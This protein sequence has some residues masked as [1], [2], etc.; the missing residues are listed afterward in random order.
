M[1]S[2]TIGEKF[3]AGTDE[4]KALAAEAL[5]KVAEV[6]ATVARAASVA[7]A[8]LDVAA[9][10]EGARLEATAEKVSLAVQEVT[11][12]VVHAAPQAAHGAAHGARVVAT[13][14]ERLL[15]G[16]KGKAREAQKPN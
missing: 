2:R 7:E 16:E 14:A 5:V 1:R 4:A 11:S 8:K 13:K 3:D 10:D 9:L 12:K 6:A 15:E